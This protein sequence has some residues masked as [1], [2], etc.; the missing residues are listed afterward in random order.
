[1]QY[2]TDCENIIFKVLHSTKAHIF[3]F[4]SFTQKDDFAAN[5]PQNEIIDT[6]SLNRKIKIDI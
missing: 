5:Y 2:N 6:Q 1:M 4:C 3:I